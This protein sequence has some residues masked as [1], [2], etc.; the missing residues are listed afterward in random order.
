M[1]IM[2]SDGILDAIKSNNKE[3]YL[4]GMISALNIKNPQIFAERLLLGVTN[5]SDAIKDDMTIIVTGI[6]SKSCKNLILA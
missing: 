4:E 6:W 1:V 5:T 3:E 2:I